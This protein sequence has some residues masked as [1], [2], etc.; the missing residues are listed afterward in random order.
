MKCNFNL[1]SNSKMVCRRRN[2]WKKVET[3]PP[4]LGNIFHPIA[5]QQ[6]AMPSSAFDHS[7][8][9]FP[10]LK[11]ELPNIPALAKD[12]STLP[13]PTSIFSQLPNG[14]KVHRSEIIMFVCFLSRLIHL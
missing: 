3:T 5:S 9:R 14:V 11:Q 8:S 2:F 13:V 6:V 12:S 10:S 1:Q 7:R 4:G